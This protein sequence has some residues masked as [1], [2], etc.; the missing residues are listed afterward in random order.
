[1]DRLKDI[2]RKITELSAADFQIL[3]DEYLYREIGNNIVGLGTQTGAHKTTIGNPDTYIH[4]RD[5]DKYIFIA[6]S[7]QQNGIYNKLK[8]D[9]EKCLN[10]ELT[11]L[12]LQYIEEIIC[13]H[14]SSNLSAGNLQN[15]INLGKPHNIKI[16]I[17][18]INKIALDI[19]N[20]YKDLAR[21]F[22]GISIDTNQIM[23]KEEFVRQY[24][25]NTIA[26]PLNTVYVARAQEFDS[27]YKSIL[28][29]NITVVR[30]QPGV[31]KTRL[32]LE[33]C[34]NLSVAENYKLLCVKN[35]YQNLYEDLVIETSESKD[36]L[37]FVDDANELASL[38]TLLKYSLSSKSKIKLVITVRDYAFEEIKNVIVEYKSHIITVEK[39]DY[40]KVKD[41]LV[42]KP[43]DGRER[44][45]GNA[46]AILP[47]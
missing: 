4:K 23:D 16:T 27:I 24:D 13:C 25:A 19:E 29:N 37:I 22:L 3:C 36:Y 42:N 46:L 1:M 31:G 2:E 30:G 34:N 15:L 28:E 7:T 41:F 33:V 39:V 32:V 47:K 21:D 20:K 18:G 9:I 12:E 14:T 38:K 45:V 17:Y 35:N 10:P 6:Y 5:S 40:E 44:M 43:S 26:A 8:E 11:K